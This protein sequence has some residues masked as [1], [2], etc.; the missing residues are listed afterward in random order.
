[1]ATSLDGIAQYLDRLGWRYEVEVNKDRVRL[2]LKTA[3][4]EKLTVVI[5]LSEGGRF[6]QFRAPKLLQLKDHVY[7]GLLFRT[8]AAITHSVKLLR[9]EYNLADSEVSAS[10]HLP[11]EDAL[12]TGWQFERCLESLVQLVDE[13]AVPRLKAVLATGQDPGRRKLAESLLEAMPED[14]VQELDQ[15][16]ASRQQRRQDDKGG[17]RLD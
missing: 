10:I 15:V 11:L 12:L 14:L 1:M 13:V 2:D 9:L 6:V 17:S 4:V 8:M 16:L 5:Q 3:N 7:I